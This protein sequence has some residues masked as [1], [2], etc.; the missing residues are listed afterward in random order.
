VVAILVYALIG[1]A[2]ARLFAIIF[3]RNVTVRR[4]SDL[5]PRGY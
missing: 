1:W 5:R 4:R 2:V 3:Y